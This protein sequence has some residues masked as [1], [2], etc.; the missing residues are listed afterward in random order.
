[1]YNYRKS[2]KVPIS[3]PKLA[4]PIKLGLALS[5]APAQTYQGWPGSPRRRSLR[6]RFGGKSSGTTA[7]WTR[8]RG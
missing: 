7:A 5:R 4:S 1:M 6:R 8:N 3:S 2:Q